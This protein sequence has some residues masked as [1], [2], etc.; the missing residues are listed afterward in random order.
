M[1]RAAIVLAVLG[2]SSCG[3][4]SGRVYDNNDLQLLTS[5]AAKELCSCI[6]VMKQSE[7][8]CNAWTKAAPD[9]KTWKADYAA[10]AI[11]TQAGL[12]FSARARYL[13]RRHGCV[14]EK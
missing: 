2:L 12:F 6:F 4:E 14:L 8:F 10:T 13:G 7:D 9:I 3:T 11:D 5:Y 1:K